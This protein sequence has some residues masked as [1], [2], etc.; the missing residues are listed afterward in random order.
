M[1]T[2]S[3][4]IPTIRVLVLT[5]RNAQI[6]QLRGLL[7]FLLFTAITAVCKG[8]GSSEKEVTDSMMVGREEGADFKSE[9][10]VVAESEIEH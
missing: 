4:L 9:L 8:E 3:P 5:R 6:M 1:K 7:F 2:A 10:E